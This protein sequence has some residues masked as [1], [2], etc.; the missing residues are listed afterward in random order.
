MTSMLA[1]ACGLV[2]LGIPA[3]QAAAQAEA[4][5]PVAPFRSVELRNGGRVILRHGPTQSVTFIKGSP[6]S[7][8]VTVSSEDGLVID[9]TSKHARGYELEIEIVTPELAGLSV[10]HGGTIQSRGSFPRQAVI[11]VSVDNG[12]TVDI[13]SMSVETISAS[14]LSGGRILATPLTL[15]A[16]TVVEGGSITYWGDARVT[17]SI[18]HGGSVTKGAP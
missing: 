14:V 2:L 7:T 9:C 1:L 13:R 4:T 16:A 3:V 5:V 12:G 15:M 10:A 6:G 11:G 17:Q 8:Q 18:E